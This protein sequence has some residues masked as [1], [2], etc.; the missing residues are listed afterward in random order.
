MAISRAGLETNKEDADAGAANECTSVESVPKI[1][2][3]LNSGVSTAD[4]H[5]RRCSHIVKSQTHLEVA[6]K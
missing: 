4:I 2:P 3:R 6:A 1:T 5:K